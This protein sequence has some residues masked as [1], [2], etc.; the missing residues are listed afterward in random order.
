MKTTNP[1]YYGM[2]V[3]VENLAGYASTRATLPPVDLSSFKEGAIAAVDSAGNLY[4]YPSAGGADL[5]DRTWISAG[6]KDATQIEVADWNSDGVQDIVAK[7]KNGNLTVSYGQPGGGLSAARIIGAGGWSGFD[8]EVAAF[9]RAD[10]YPGII[11]RNIADGKLYY[12]TNPSGGAHGSRT[13]IGSYFKGLETFALDYDADGK[14]D[15]IAR[16]PTGT[17]Q[18]KLYRSN[19]AGTFYSETRKVIRTSGWNKM[20]HLSSI[21]DHLG[22]GEAGIL[23]REKSGDLRYFKVTRNKVQSGI[24]IGRGGWDT[25][26]LGS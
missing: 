6:W 13:K 12:Y 18:L 10:K 4:V 26:L 9:R 25:L 22:T 14:M 2:Y 19:G 17:G 11:A 3:V 15:L 16:T 1:D 7:R 5:W 23:A 8:I 20:A 21:T 24:Y